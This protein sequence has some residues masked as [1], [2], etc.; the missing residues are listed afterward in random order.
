MNPDD[1]RDLI[2]QAG[3]TVT[4]MGALPDGSGFATASFSAAKN[5]WSTAPDYAVPPMPFR[6]GHGERAVVAVF[7][8]K[9]WPDRSHRM[10]KDEFADHIK[11]ACRYAYRASTMNGTE[12]DLDPDALVQNI[13]N[14]LLGYWTETGLSMDEW[15]NPKDQK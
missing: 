5:H 4:D 6:M 2:E 1:V 15:A 9:G 14:G 13:V 11:A 12:T 7:P 3:G 8:N 10:T